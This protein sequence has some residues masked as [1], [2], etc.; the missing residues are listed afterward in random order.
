MQL[1]S[2]AFCTMPCINHIKSHPLLYCW[3]IS[4]TPFVFE[5]SNL[6]FIFMIEN[7]SNKI[8]RKTVSFMANSVHS[9]RSDWIWLTTW[10]FQMAWSVWGCF[11]G[12]LVF[13]TVIITA[14]IIQCTK[15]QAS[16]SIWVLVYDGTLLFIPAHCNSWLLD[17]KLPVLVSPDRPLICTGQKLCSIHFYEPH[18]LL[19]ICAYT[20]Q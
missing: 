12:F 6:E 16:Y 15:Q 8:M 7:Y 13:L 9:A 18:I 20:Y 4:P 11:C 2:L 14:V 10:A 1:S 5:T 3:A 17:G 19:H